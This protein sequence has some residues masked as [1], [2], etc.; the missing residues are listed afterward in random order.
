MVEKRGI[1]PVVVIAG[2]V[3]LALAGV[4][5]LFAL[6]RAAPGPPS[7]QPG[8]A[9]LFGFITDGETGE[10]IA[11]ADITVY[12]DYDSDTIPYHTTTDSQGYYQILDMLVE[13]EVTQMAV[14]ASGYESYANEDIPLAEGNNELS[15]TMAPGG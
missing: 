8:L 13:V 2:G 3:G 15:F 12:Q 14:Y 11:G 5:V 1:S 10:P 7:P 9:N 4:V 6:G